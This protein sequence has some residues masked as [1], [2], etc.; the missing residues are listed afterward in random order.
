MRRGEKRRRL[1][2]RTLLLL[3]IMVG[4]IRY[5]AISNE[6]CLTDED[7]ILSSER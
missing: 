1:L 4:L 2:S 3:N 6:E 5:E 7:S